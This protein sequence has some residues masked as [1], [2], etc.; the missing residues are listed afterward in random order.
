MR[1]CGGGVCAPARCRGD[2][3][4]SEMA[5]SMFYGRQLAAAALRSHRPQATLRAAAQVGPPARFSLG[6][7]AA[8]RRGCPRCWH[9][10]G[11]LWSAATRLRARSASRRWGSSAPT[12]VLGRP[13]PASWLPVSAP[14]AWRGSLRAAWGRPGRGLT[15]P[16]SF[17]VRGMPFKCTFA[18]RAVV[19]WEGLRNYSRVGL[20]T[21][22]K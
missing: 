19:R 17:W 16:G 5:A 10:P 7:S 14:G 15:L 11:A 6:G 9:V 13:G 20:P 8:R 4:D 1:G 21:L 12:R 22:P 18:S 2:G 3:S